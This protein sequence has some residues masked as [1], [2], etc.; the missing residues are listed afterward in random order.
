MDDGQLGWPNVFTSVDAAGEMRARFAVSGAILF[1]ALS[2]S[3]LVGPNYKRPA[4][5]EPTVYRGASSDQAVKP[6]VASFGDQEW[7]EVFQ[8]DALL[9]WKTAAAIDTTAPVC[10][11]SIP[12]SSDGPAK[13][14][15]R[16]CVAAIPEPDNTANPSDKSA[17]SGNRS[18]G[19]CS[20]H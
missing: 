1:A 7:W 14:P 2:S 5:V 4:V 11:G 15:N 17:A 20:I 18:P 8:D 13:K 16:L 6:D 12:C 10:V 3:C 19:A 9:P